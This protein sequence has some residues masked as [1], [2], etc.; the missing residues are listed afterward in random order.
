MIW[1]RPLGSG[2]SCV[3]IADSFGVTMFTDGTD[4]LLTAFDP[5]T[6]KE[7]WRYRIAKMYQGHTGSDDGPTSTPVIAD[8]TVYGLGPRGHLF[9]VRLADG[10][11]IW[12]R[13]LSETDSRSPK[14]GFTTVPLV[15][16]DLVIVQ[17]GGADGHAVTA[18]A[19]DTGELCWSL[20]DDTVQ[21]QSPA[22]LEL[23][24]RRQVVAITDRYL[25][26]IA[27]A[28]GEL[29]WRQEHKLELTEAY[30]LPQLHSAERLLITSVNEL[31]SLEIANQ[32]AVPGADLALRE[33]WRLSTHGTCFALPVSH[34]GYIYT[35]VNRRFLYCVDAET[36]EIMWKSRASGG[37]G[38][39]LVD[40]QLVMLSPRGD[41]VIINASP[42]GY[43]EKV[44]LSVFER[45][46]LTAPT[47]ADGR[48]YLRNL[49][50]LAAVRLTEI[51]NHHTD[52]ERELLGKFG[53]FVQCA[54]AADD[55]RQLVE[56]LLAA[57][58][59]FPIIEGQDLVHFIY[60]GKVQDVAVTGN[61]LP[62]P[63]ERVMDRI[64]G[65]DVY[66]K[67]IRLDPEAVFDY[68]YSVDF[69]NLIPDPRNPH[70]ITTLSG[71][72][73]ILRM[74]H[75]KAPLTIEE[76][77]EPHQGRLE[78]FQLHSRFRSN[79][80][81]VQI[82]L[83]NEYDAAPDTRYPVLLVTYGLDALST[84]HMDRW[85][86]RLILEGRMQPLIAVFFQEAGIT[87]FYGPYAEDLLRMLTEELIPHVDAHYRTIPEPGSRALLGLLDGGEFGVWAAFKAPGCYSRIALQSL[88]YLQ[89]PAINEL[90][91]LI[92]SV[93]KQ[94]LDFYFELRR[95]YIKGEGIDYIGNSIALK[96]LLEKA[97]YQV[98]QHEV[99]GS[100]GWS[101]W[102]AQYGEILTH[103]FP[104]Q[105]VA[106]AK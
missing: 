95:N 62:I 69:G 2:Y 103:L 46:G 40:G 86:D 60:K 82:Y 66:F 16:R 74:P 68:Q 54:E 98:E 29:L 8:G 20:G 76:V 77:D 101:S 24:G 56:E 19:R 100:W 55:P 67:S 99:P 89:P 50:E 4:D 104:P 42:K 59:S 3:L 31:V 88:V 72:G 12:S 80:R 105:P 70:G 32:E 81:Q 90:P 17:T 39:I 44:R 58:D 45:G 57:Q 9:A 14:Y 106:A 36:G 51:P 48:I 1:K 18:F 43:H 13:T 22:L 6:G 64:A 49:S 30:N 37:E 15:V 63:E 21:Y 28:K 23:A 65:T 10:N 93:E 33:R 27:P 73:S 71:P 87:E 97:G 78:S 92:E 11:E 53:D 84:G 38:L 26:G 85:L 83:P 102:R 94:P 52:Q 75:S 25:M 79:E 5:D 7:L 41:L 47:F 61:F 34:D 96:Q 35:G 91:A